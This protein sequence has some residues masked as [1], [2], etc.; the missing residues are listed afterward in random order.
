[1]LGN[2][3][4]QVRPGDAAFGEWEAVVPR[5]F[6]F[7]LKGLAYLSLRLGR[8]EI[9][10]EAAEKLLELDPLDRIGA[11]VLIDVLDR[12]AVEDE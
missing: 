10:R 12:L 6:Q 7:S 5:F 4:R 2:D 8:L 1:M 3:W 9:G 11:R